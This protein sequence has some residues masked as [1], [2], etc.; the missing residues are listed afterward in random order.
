M[1]ISAISM[2]WVFSTVQ[3]PLL[4]FCLESRRRPIH[5]EFHVNLLAVLEPQNQHLNKDVA[6]ASC[7]NQYEIL[8]IKRLRNLYLAV[9]LLGQVNC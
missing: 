9:L 2:L 8:N 6:I 3:S 4:G 5:L 7:D 1:P